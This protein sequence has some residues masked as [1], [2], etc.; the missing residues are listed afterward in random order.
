MSSRTDHTG[1]CKSLGERERERRNRG[2][3][4]PFAP[5]NKTNSIKSFAGERK[6]RKKKLFYL[7][8]KNCP[9]SHTCAEQPAMPARKE[10]VVQNV[11][12]KELTT[13]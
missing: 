12:V 11:S 4:F 8:E 9:R 3:G 10:E 13:L 6:E 5:A 2:T 1:M 7:S